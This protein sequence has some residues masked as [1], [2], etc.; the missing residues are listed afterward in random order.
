[1]FMGDSEGEAFLEEHARRL[2]VIAY[3]LMEQENLR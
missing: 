3:L 2:N 1:M